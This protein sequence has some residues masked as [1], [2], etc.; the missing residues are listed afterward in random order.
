MG[1]SIS[2]SQIRNITNLGEDIGETFI[3]LTET[4]LSLV[5]AQIDH[6]GDFSYRGIRRAAVEAY[7]LENRYT[8]DEHRDFIARHGDAS[9]YYSNPADLRR[10]IEQMRKDK[11]TNP[12]AFSDRKQQ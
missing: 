2:E 7:F 5:R 12:L 10:D 4:Q 11:T 8:P 3:D 1:S 9:A 6:T